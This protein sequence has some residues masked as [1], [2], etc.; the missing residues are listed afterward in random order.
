WDAPAI[1]PQRGCIKRQSCHLARMPG[2]VVE[3]QDGAHRQASDDDSVARLVH[4][5]VF[6]LDASVP[7]LPGGS[8][9]LFSAAAVTGK[10]RHMHRMAGAGQGLGEVAHFNGR[11]S[12]PMNEE[13]AQGTSTEPNAVVEKAHRILRADQ[14]CRVHRVAGTRATASPIACSRFASQ[15]D[16][17]TV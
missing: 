16:S 10:L 13:D 8:L 2:R 11:S 6:E 3:R 9:E 17:C 12:K 1:E 4:A 5:P 15:A 7:I 14:P